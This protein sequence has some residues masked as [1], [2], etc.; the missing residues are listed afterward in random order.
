M[1]TVALVYKLLGTS[2]L[3]TAR[4]VS[5]LVGGLTLLAVY[6]YCKQRYKP[7]TGILACLLL[8]T[9][10]FFLSFAR[11]AFTETDI[12]LACTLAWLLICVTRL[13]ARPTLGWAAVAGVVLGL[14]LSAKFTALVVLPAVWYAVSQSKMTGSEK[15]LSQV[16]D[17]FVYFWTG[18]LFVCTICGLIAAQRIHSETG[19]GSSRLILYGLVLSGWI[20]PLAWSCFAI[21]QSPLDWRWLPSLPVWRCSPSWFCLPNISPILLFFKACCGEQSMKWL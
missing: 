14:A 13:Q 2:D 17:S 3:I 19:L 21:H 7:S 15:D 8:A 4:L 11:V 18:W 10:P 1:F 5:C 9:S 20:I 12:Y 16:K 6:L